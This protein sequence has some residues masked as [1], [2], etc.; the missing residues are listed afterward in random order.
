LERIIED[1]LVPDVCVLDVNM[2]VLNGFETAK[3]LRYKCPGMKIL[4]FSMNN[5]EKNIVGMLRSGA[6]GYITKGG[7][8]EELKKAIETVYRE[9]CYFNTEVGKTIL[10]YLRKEARN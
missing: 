5:D 2:P 7:S 9:G 6:N 10:H 8:P 3:A 4:A 1:K